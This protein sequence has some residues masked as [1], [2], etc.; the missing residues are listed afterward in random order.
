MRWSRVCVVC[1][2][3]GLVLM[4]ASWSVATTRSSGA[5]RRTAAVSPIPAAS[6]A[7]QR[8]LQ[9]LVARL[10]AV[11]LPG[12]AGHAVVP[13]LGGPRVQGMTCFVATGAC[14]LVPCVEFAAGGGC[15]RHA[16]G[17][18]LVRVIGR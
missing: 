3:I 10:P 17:P 7:L 5:A 4:A 9:Q 16:G 14:S 6:G 11:A 2:V 18:Y 13:P 1:G 8:Q 15:L 12:R